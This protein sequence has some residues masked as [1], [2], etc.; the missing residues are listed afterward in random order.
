MRHVWDVNLSITRSQDGRSSSQSLLWTS[1]YGIAVLVGIYIAIYPAFD[2][3]QLLRVLKAPEPINSLIVR[4]SEWPLRWVLWAF[5]IFH[6]TPERA[7]EKLRTWPTYKNA[8]VYLKFKLA[9]LL[10]AIAFLFGGFGIFNHLLFNVR[11]SFGSFCK[12]TADAEGPLHSGNDGFGEQRRKRIMVFDSSWTDA[13][14]LCFSTGVF[15]TRGQKYAISVSRTP[16]EAEWSAEIPWTFWSEPTFMS[17]QPVSSLPWWKQPVMAVMLPFRRTL[18]RP[19][20]A[21]IVRYGPTGTEESFLDREP[22]ALDD[23]LIDDPNYKAE[24]IPQKKNKYEKEDHEVLG[25]GWTA[26]RDGEIYV[27]L[28]KPVLGIWGMETLV[29]RYLFPNTGIAHIDIQKR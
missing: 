29:G 22:P 24:S 12:H 4:Y 15:A 9:P 3:H 1:F 20:G 17:G 16:F 27:Y 2:W 7:I 18:D 23:D 25:E 26:T 28:N 8:L 19:W 21:F 6:L 14:S 10:F 5:L 13:H 11:D